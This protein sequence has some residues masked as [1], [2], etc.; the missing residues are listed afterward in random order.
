M[1]DQMILAHCQV[2]PLL[3]GILEMQRSGRNWF[4][5][6]LDSLRAVLG[7]L[8]YPL[9]TLIHVWVEIVLRSEACQ[10]ESQRSVCC[11]ELI[12]SLKHLA[13]G[14]LTANSLLN[15]TNPLIKFIVIQFNE[16]SYLDLFFISA[17][18]LHQSFQLFLL[19]LSFLLH[20]HLPDFFHLLLS[21]CLDI[22]KSMGLH[23]L[24]L[25]LH[26]ATKV[27]DWS[28]TSNWRSLP[29]TIVICTIKTL[30]ALQLFFLHLVILILKSVFFA[31]G[32]FKLFRCT[33]NTSLN[34]VTSTVECRTHHDGVMFLFGTCMVKLLSIYSAVIDTYM[35]L[36]GLDIS[37][38][39]LKH[40]ILDLLE[41]ER[42]YCFPI[43]LLSVNSILFVSCP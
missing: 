39:S 34:E 4:I 16:W 26:G 35:P 17:A 1:P 18:I 20:L 3:V 38:L 23:R 13:A 30:F 9:L 27:V 43:W 31:Q 14:R 21:T 22:E 41:L 7:H 40:S 25:I 29:L 24:T 5:V 6:G 19:F 12:I 15:L 33:N 42:I 11:I 8:S 36:G 32:M 37:H 2:S 28:D 10:L